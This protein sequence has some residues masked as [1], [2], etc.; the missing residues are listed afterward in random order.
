MKAKEEKKIEEEIVYVCASP[1][2]QS[3]SVLSKISE[4]TGN[5]K[6]KKN[7]RRKINCVT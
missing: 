3:K 7:V 1:Q 6:K 4:I 5:N 2:L